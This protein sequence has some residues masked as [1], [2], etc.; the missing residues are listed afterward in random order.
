MAQKQ[1]V[2]WSA[3]SLLGDLVIGVGSVGTASTVITDA[4]RTEPD[5]NWRGSSFYIYDGVNGAVV[6]GTAY[7]DLNSDYT[8]VTVSSAAETSFTINVALATAST[9]EKY[10]LHSIPKEDYDRA[11]NMAFE[12]IKG[13]ALLP[14]VATTTMTAQEI[15]VETLVASGWTHIYKVELDRDF[16]WERL[17]PTKWTTITGENTL[18]LEYNIFSTYEDSAMR[19]HGFKEPTEP[20]HDMKEYDLP[21]EGHQYI[22][23]RTAS[24]LMPQNPDW[25]DAQQRARLSSRW[26]QEAVRLRKALSSILPANVRQ[27]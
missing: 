6:V 7:S 3:A 23:Y 14:T 18:K 11:M 4:R 19:L 25:F 13:V 17:R 24:L 2:R 15:N 20:D 21:R 27:L 12:E 26:E 10:E 16:G 5:N 8:V 1:L 22:I 9:T